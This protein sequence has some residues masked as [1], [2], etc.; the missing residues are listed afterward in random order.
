MEQF[1]TIINSNTPVLVDFFATWCGPCKMMAPIL[2][3]VKSQLGENIR[4]LKIDVDKN[5][6]LA[7]QFQIRSVPT[8]KIFQNGQ[9]KWTG[10]GVVQADQLAAVIQ[11]VTRLQAT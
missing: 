8:L 11:S 9:V 7:Q 4:I 3:Q 1:K 2:E 10:N 5:P 6:A